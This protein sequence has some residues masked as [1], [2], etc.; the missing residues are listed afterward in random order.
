MKIKV[1]NNANEEEQ[2]LKDNNGKSIYKVLLINMG[3]IS[4]IKLAE[5]ICKNKGESLIFGYHF[6]AHTRSREKN[7]VKYDKRFDLSFSFE[8]IVYALKQIFINN[9][10]II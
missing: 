10:S 7:S 8:G 1:V 4:E 6:G 9:T 3:I 2:K 5:K